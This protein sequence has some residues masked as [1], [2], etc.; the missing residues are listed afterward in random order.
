MEQRTVL[1]IGILCRRYALSHGTLLSGRSV[2]DGGITIRRDI[3]RSASRFHGEGLLTGRLLTT[4]YGTAVRVGIFT[5]G[6]II[7]P[8]LRGEITSPGFRG[9]RGIP[10]LG[11]KISGFGLRR[12]AAPFHLAGLSRDSLYLLVLGQRLL[13]CNGYI[14]FSRHL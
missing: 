4:A 5:R 12:E 8:R 6:K 10:S 9:R 7:G 3:I 14:L 2:L 11:G 1:G 13:G